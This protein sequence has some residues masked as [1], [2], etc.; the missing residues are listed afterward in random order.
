MGRKAGVA[1]ETTRAALLESAALVFARRGYDGA[2]ISEI[3]SEAGLTSGAIYAHY[4]SKAELFVATLKAYGQRDLD[5]VVGRSGADLVEALTAAGAEFDRRQPTEASLLIAAI[6]AARQHP[7]VHQLISVLMG[8]REAIFR[9]LVDEAQAAGVLS[10]EVSAG[11]LSRM[12][13]MLA[14]GSLVVGAM[15]LDAVEH[16]EWAHLM[17]KLVGGFAGPT[18]AGPAA[19]GAGRPGAAPGG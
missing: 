1:A 19:P 4:S 3:C 6:V 9:S 10:S 15:Q 7:E 11:A 17:V 5:R 8:D 12:S 14:L 13:L 16:Q 2:S 18:V